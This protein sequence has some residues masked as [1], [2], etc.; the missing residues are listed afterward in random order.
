MSEFQV[1][2][3]LGLFFGLAF[4]GMFRGLVANQ[5]LEIKRLQ[6]LTSLLREKLDT[7]E[8]E[9]HKCRLEKQEVDSELDDYVLA[10]QLLKNQIK[11]LK[12]D[13]VN[14]KGLRRGEQ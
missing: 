9:Y 5:A 8:D 3:L 12:Q 14:L 4:W 7:V 13:I 6:E 10:N 1:V 2:A 11:D